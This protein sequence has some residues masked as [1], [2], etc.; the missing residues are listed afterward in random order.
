[1][2]HISIFGLAAAILAGVSM[3]A[4]QAG[5]DNSSGSRLDGEWE[6]VQSQAAGQGTFKHRRE[7]KLIADNHFIWVIYD[8]KSRTPIVMGGGICSLAGNEYTEQLEFGE[9]RLR[10]LLDRPQHFQAQSDGMTW[11]HTGVL[12]DGSRVQEIWRR[13]Q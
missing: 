2:R 3:A 4:P 8:T 7:I 9:V 13:V 10:G 5:S 11:R 1:M 6:L 12:S